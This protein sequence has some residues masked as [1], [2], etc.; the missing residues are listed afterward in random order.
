MTQEERPRRCEIVSRS[1]CEPEA[2]GKQ[3]D[4]QVALRDYGKFVIMNLN[5][6]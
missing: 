2:A 6:E 4:C 5:T 1:V 3:Y